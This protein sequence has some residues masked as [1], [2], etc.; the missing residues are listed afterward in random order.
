MVQRQG[1]RHDLNFLLR[2]S[3]IRTLAVAESVTCGRL[4]ARIGEL[5]GASRFFLGGITTYTLPEKVRHLGVDRAAA[6]RVDCVSAQ[7]AAEMAAGVCR[8]FGSEVGAGVT[9]YAEPLAERG[10]RE[11][12]AWWALAIRRRGRVRQVA[13]GRIECP[14]ASRLEAQQIIADGVLAELAAYLRAAQA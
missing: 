14:G 11:P 7:V 10:V 4:Q 12:H 8:L 6:R 2:Q 9:G 5:S 13:A 3:P 1:V